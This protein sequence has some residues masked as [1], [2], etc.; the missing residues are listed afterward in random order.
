MNWLL[1]SAEEIARINQYQPIIKNYSKHIK[2]RIKYGV[3]SELLTLLRFKGIGRT[4]ARKLFRAGIKT[5]QDVKKTNIETLASIV[6]PKLAKSLHEETGIRVEQE[7]T[8]KEKGLRDQEEETKHK[9]TK[10][11]AF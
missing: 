3:K 5:I 7:P 9:Q 2:E 8:N 10:L 6:G 1:Y 11:N 4:R